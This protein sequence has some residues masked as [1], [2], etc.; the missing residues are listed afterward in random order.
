MDGDPA[1]PRQSASD[2]RRKEYDIFYGTSGNEDR[3]WGL[4]VTGLACLVG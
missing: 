3:V 2:G 4:I 1:Q